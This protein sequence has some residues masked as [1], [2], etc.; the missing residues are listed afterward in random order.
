MIIYFAGRNAHGISHK[1]EA[2]RRNQ[3]DKENDVLFMLDE[4]GEKVLYRLIPFFYS[5]TVKSVMTV[6]KRKEAKT[7]AGKKKKR[8]KK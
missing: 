8:A 7:D 2:E 4:R 3:V 5:E 1:K 6:K